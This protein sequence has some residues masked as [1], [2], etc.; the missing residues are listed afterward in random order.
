[1]KLSIVYITGHQNRVLNDINQIQTSLLWAGL[2]NSKQ[3][4]NKLSTWTYPK[5]T[6]PWQNKPVSLEQCSPDKQ[7]NKVEEIEAKICPQQKQSHF[8]ARMQRKHSAASRV[9]L[10]SACVRRQWGLFAATLSGPEWVLSP[11]IQPFMNMEFCGARTLSNLSYYGR[12][13]SIP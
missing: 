12:E 6:L 7:N 2:I 5:N 13:K 8:A 10:S 9:N 11:H 1:M 3:T 4:T